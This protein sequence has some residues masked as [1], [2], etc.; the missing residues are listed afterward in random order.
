MILDCHNGIAGD[1]CED[2]GNLVDI[3]SFVTVFDVVV[4][5]GVNK[6][7]FIALLDRTS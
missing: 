7:H 2:L 3:F 1:A 4:E 5:Y 6:S